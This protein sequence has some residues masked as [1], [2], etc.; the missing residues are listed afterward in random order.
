MTRI[1]QEM[2]A[3]RA[4]SGEGVLITRERHRRHMK[5][6]L[7]HLEN[8]LDQSLSMDLAAEELRQVAVSCRHYYGLPI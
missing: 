7:H 6:C 4:S 5:E 1:V 8:F 3:S 2:F